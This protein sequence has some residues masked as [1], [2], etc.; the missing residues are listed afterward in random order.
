MGQHY[1]PR[2]E[3]EGGWRTNTDPSFVRSLG[4]DPE[5]L[6]EFGQY[7][8][9]VPNT[10]WQPYASYKGIVVIKDGWII[11]E[12]YNTPA[13]KEF[14]TYLSSNGKAFA[15]ICTGIL[16]EDSTQGRI[17]FQIQPESKVYNQKWLPEGF[18]LSDPRKRRISFEHIFQHTSGLCPER[19]ADGKPVERG[20]N[21][22]TDYPGWVVGHDEKW[23]STKTL[24]FA[25]GR[26]AEY[27]G[28]ETNG[29][30]IYSYSSIAMNH[31]GLVIQN[32]YRIPARGF[33]WERLLEPIGF[34]GIDFD[35]PPS[36][37][38][39]WVTA[40]GLRMTPRDYARFAYFLLRDGRWED[41][42]LVPRSW[43]RRFRLSHRYPNIRSNSDGVFGEQYPTDMF[44][45]AGSGLNWAY[46]IPSLD[47]IAIRTG[48]ASNTQWDEVRGIFLEKL[49]AAVAVTRS[50]RNP[51]TTAGKAPER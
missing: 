33:L 45:I 38:I 17:P 14:K 25:P 36:E 15:M 4:I 20:R 48:R 27:A 18:P 47:L 28:S 40:G 1:F 16:V 2:A 49:F 44:R 46:M 39:K 41:R 8:L 30:H 35:R 23:P 31:L 11:G 50:G 13:A 3:A 12:W 22:W 6:E 29:G 37:Q 19:T 5:K 43:I 9:S 10:N 7:N 24:Y 51:D 32:I 26:P 42:Q 34:S 21:E